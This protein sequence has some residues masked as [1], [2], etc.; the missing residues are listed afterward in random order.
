MKNITMDDLQ[1]KDSELQFEQEALERE[2]QVEFQ[3]D[4]LMDKSVELINKKR[5]SRDDE[6]YH[7]MWFTYYLSNWYEWF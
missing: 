4:S 1:L 2:Q 5:S 7:L 6:I 3:L